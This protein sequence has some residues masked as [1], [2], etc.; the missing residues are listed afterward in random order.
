MF[1]LFSM[2]MNLSSIYAPMPIAAGSLRPAQSKLVPALLQMLL[3]A[4]LF[5][6]TQAFTL[7]PLGIEALLHWQKLASGVPVA[8][9]LALGQCAVITV[10][11]Y[12]VL[13]AQG[14]MLQA[15]EQRILDVVTNR[16]P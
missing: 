4:L 13:G 1:L 9:L 8:L 16:V 10:L 15:R 2:L 14:R 3:F 5:P 11:Y 12:F 7:L 6:L